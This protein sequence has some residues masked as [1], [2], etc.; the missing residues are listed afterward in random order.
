MSLQRTPQWY[1]KRKGKLT[2]SRINEI[3]RKRSDGQV[4]RMREKYSTELAMERLGHEIK[5]VPLTP[6]IKR[7]IRLEPIA[8]EKYSQK[9]GKSL[10]LVDFIEHPSIP[11]AGFSP[12]AIV[13]DRLVEVKCPRLD[14][15]MDLFFDKSLANKYLPQIHWG[16]AHGYSGCDL[17]SYCEEAP[18]GMELIIIDVECDTVYQAELESEARLFLTEVDE[19]VI[20][21][22]LELLKAEFDY[23]SPL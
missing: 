9:I 4:S 7:G 23:Q 19:K 8:L 2:G 22:K 5:K 17:V 3:I 15:H 11:M 16:M 13:G 6:D 1:E 20:R 12:D 18:E 10:K 14:R 21:M